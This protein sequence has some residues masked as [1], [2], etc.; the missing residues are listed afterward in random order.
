[1]LYRGMD[2]TTLDAAYD[3][4]GHVGQAVRDR[5]VLDWRERSAVVRRR[6]G[7]RS[8]LAYG[9]APRQRLDVFPS[10]RSGDP[11]LVYFH[12]GYW[13]ANDKE[14]DAF[15]AD[16][17][18]SRGFNGVLVEYTIAP[19]ARMDAI[20]AE[21]RAGVRWVV[22]HAPEWGG[23]RRRIFVA[24]HSAGAQLAAMAMNEEGV[25]GGISIS[26]VF[27]LEPVRLSGLNDQLGL[28]FAEAERNSPLRRLP[29]HSAPLL[30]AVGLGELGEFVRQSRELAAAWQRAGLPVTLLELPGHNHFT[31]LEELAQP[32]GAIL[33]WLQALASG[34]APKPQLIP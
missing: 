8:D 13:Q 24:G 21:A 31:I 15:V 27:D 4:V 30:I 29:A 25:A 7:V 1:M 18:L 22:E 19:A 11:T 34:P 14:R 20:V 5:I 12:G 9:P 33:A 17:A 23:D 3:N 26:G 32:G 6:R 10:G 2:R 16:G 28:D